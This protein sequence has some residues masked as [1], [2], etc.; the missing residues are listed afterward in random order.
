MKVSETD[1]MHEVKKLDELKLNGQDTKSQ[2]KKVVS[3]IKN[4][5]SD[6][7]RDYHMSISKTRGLIQFI[8]NEHKQRKAASAE[9]NKRRIK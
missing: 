3:I 2:H 9:A 1:L 6:L 4:Y 5:N 7:D 8:A